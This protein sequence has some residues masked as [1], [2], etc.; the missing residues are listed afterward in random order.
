MVIRGDM[1]NHGFA[2]KKIHDIV[3]CHVKLCKFVKNETNSPF[4]TNSANNGWT[5]GARGIGSA[6]MFLGGETW[7]IVVFW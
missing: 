2:V 5:Q 4:F 6:G 1:A 3:R 7:S